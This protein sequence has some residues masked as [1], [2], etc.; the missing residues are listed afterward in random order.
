MYACV[1]V[2]ASGA[3]SN[4]RMIAILFDTLVSKNFL[5]ARE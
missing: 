5:M 4:L 3:V 1:N 2:M